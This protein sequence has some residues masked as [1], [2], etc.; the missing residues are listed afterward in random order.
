VYSRKIYLDSGKV[1]R[2]RDFIYVTQGQW[3]HEKNDSNADHPYLQHNFAIVY[4]TGYT[5]ATPQNDP[6]M[7]I[8]DAWQTLLPYTYTTSNFFLKIDKIGEILTYPGE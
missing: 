6:V 4:P 1:I 5:V 2:L 3:N 7:V 8:F